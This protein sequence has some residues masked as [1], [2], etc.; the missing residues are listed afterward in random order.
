MGREP[1]TLYARVTT[2]LRYRFENLEQARAHV[3]DVEGSAL[4]FCRDEQICFLPD[5]PVCLSFS[6]SGGQVDRLLHGHVAA[7]AEGGGTW[8]EVHDTRPLRNLTPTEAVRRSVRMGCDAPVA[9]HSASRAATLRMLDLGVGGARLCGAAGFDPGERLDLRLLSADRLTFHDLSYA[10]VVWAEGEE[11]GV[12]FDRAD[13]VGRRAVSRLIAE[14]EEL[15]EKAWQGEH[16]AGCCSDGV[17][18]EPQPPAAR[19]L[20]RPASDDVSLLARG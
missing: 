10:H 7:T 2:R 8:I 4:F 1:L 16:A 18:L 12:R 11:V 5:A 9:A 14:T 15:W 19:T 17:L 13:G 3:R 6:F 20:R